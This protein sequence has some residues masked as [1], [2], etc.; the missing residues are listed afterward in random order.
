MGVS[1]SNLQFF[2]LVTHGKYLTFPLKPWVLKRFQCQ[3][4]VGK[5]TQ[6]TT[7][8]YN[9]SQV[10]I[11]AVTGDIGFLSQFCFHNV[12]HTEGQTVKMMIIA[13]SPS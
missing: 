7:W 9:Q 3:K 4:W 11:D 12:A 1:W 5:R 10:A 2:S 8:I 13:C 6:A